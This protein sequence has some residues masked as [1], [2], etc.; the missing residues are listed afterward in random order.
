MFLS[1]LEGSK[2][3]FDGLEENIIEVNLERS[4]EEKD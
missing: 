3:H 2:R 1:S 4:I